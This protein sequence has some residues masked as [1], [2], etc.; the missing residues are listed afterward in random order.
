MPRSDDQI[1]HFLRGL[2]DRLIEA[3]TQPRFSPRAA[4]DVGAQLV[5]QGFVGEES[6]GATVKLLAHALPAHSELRTVAELPGKIASLLGELASGYATA[7]RRRTL[8]QQEDVKSALVRSIREGEARFREVFSSTPVGSA[9]SELNGAVT[10]SNAALADILGYAPGQLV[11]RDVRELFHPEDAGLLAAIYRD[12]ADGLRSRFRARVKLLDA[13][14]DTTWASLAVSV[15]RDAAGSPTHHV[16]MVE[17]VTDVHLLEER[18]RHQTLHDLLTELPNQEYFWIHLRSVLERARPGAN[19]TLC[20]IDLDGFAVVNDGHGHEAGN[21]VLCSVATR[22]KQLVED[23]RAMVARFGADEFAIVIEESA[24]PL[25]LVALAKAINAELSEPVYLGDY[26]L[27]VSA[28]IGLAR[29]PAHGIE[30]AELVRAADTTLHRAKR[31]GRAQWGLDDPHADAI[32]RA[33]YTLAMSM[34]GAWEDGQVTLRYQPLVRLDPAAADSGRIVAVQALLHWEHPQRGVLAPEECVALAEQTGLVISLGPWML[35][36]ACAA[37]RAWRDLL[38]SGTPPLRVDLTAHLAQD[39]DLMA[40]LR[41]ALGASR[42]R[43][44]DLQLGIP[45]GPIV[46]GCHDTED[47]LRALADAGV[48]TLFTR[49]GQTPG[50]LAVLENRHVQAVDITDPSVRVDVQQPESI[51]LQALSALVP[52]I[53]TTGTAVVVGGVGSAEEADWWRSIGV[54]SARGAAFAAPCELENIPALLV[55]S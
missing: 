15:L 8:D 1:A 7:L 18:L 27:A 14:G 46:A 4:A 55:E 48:R 35:Q 41:D 38:G 39:P 30:A 47:N 2:L 40:V 20:K 33:R 13:K 37:L 26:G 51:V 29:R 22:L 19:V 45:V 17:D 54:D 52:V 21:L 6:L 24:K 50:N 53:R 36:Q 23:Q 12:L 43:P 42:L 9:I 10:Q 3:L 5:R 16:T 32:E 25:D 28:G 11:G 31:I 44:E 34:P 49:Y